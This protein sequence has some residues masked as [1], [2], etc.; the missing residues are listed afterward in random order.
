MDLRNQIVKELKKPGKSACDHAMAPSTT[1]VC[2]RLPRSV[3][4]AGAGQGCVP[5]S[6]VLGGSSVITAGTL[7][8]RKAFINELKNQARGFKKQSLIDELEKYER[9]IAE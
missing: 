4:H 2:R 5:S 1:D 3:P 9:T 7:S 8:D 6:S